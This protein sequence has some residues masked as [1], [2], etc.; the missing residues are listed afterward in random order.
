MSAAANPVIRLRPRT[1]VAAA[2]TNCFFIYAPFFQ[3]RP[4]VFGTFWAED[5]A[6]H[7]AVCLIRLHCGAR[8]SSQTAL[9]HSRPE[10]ELLIV[11]SGDFPMWLRIRG[12]AKAKPH[13]KTILPPLRRAEILLRYVRAI[14]AGL[15]AAETLRSNARA[16]RAAAATGVAGDVHRG[17]PA[18]RGGD[19]LLGRTV[20]RHGDILAVD[21]DSH[22]GAIA[23]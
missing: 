1:E 6:P 16:E 10:I 11:G 20:L 17:R 12:G 19:G 9:E 7:S 5:C 18:A 22:G 3:C 2:R 21:R 14:N 13:R 23:S 8:L 15:V 4:P